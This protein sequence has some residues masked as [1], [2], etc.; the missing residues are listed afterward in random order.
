MLYNQTMKQYNIKY[1]ENLS[2]IYA[3]KYRVVWCSKYLRPVLT[4]PVFERLKEVIQVIANECNA[5]LIELEIMPNQVHLLVEINPQLGI[6]KLIK[7]MKARSSS[8]I[9]SEFDWIR[10]RLPT[11]WSNSYM[12]TTIGSVSDQVIRQFVEQ[13][14]NI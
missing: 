5:E 14:K 10:S 6:H 12:V 7:L 2:V 9:R 8:L 11:L 13:Q 4:G 1:K 3:C